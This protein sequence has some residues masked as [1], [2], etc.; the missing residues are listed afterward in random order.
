MDRQ[1]YNRKLIFERNGQMNNKVKRTGNLYVALVVILMVVAVV[2]AIAGAMSRSAQVVDVGVDGNAVTNAAEDAG[3]MDTEDVADVFKPSKDNESDSV[4]DAVTEKTEAE[5][6][7]QFINPTG[8]KLI[9]EYSIE[10]PVF[11][12]TMEDYRTHSGVDIFV[13]NGERILAA[14]GG[15]VKE[16]W[17]DPMMGTCISISHAG[18]A[19]SIYMN[20]SPDFPE[21]IAVGA[22][23]S[24]GTF[25]A[26]GGESALAEISEEPHVHFELKI[27]GEY[28]DPCDYIDFSQGEEIYED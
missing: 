11:S 5:P 14:A 27:N 3:A 28:V 16:I 19:E 22:N 15:T 7:P 17:E 21:G 12:V 9:S 10:V 8:G 6:I 4:T 25:I 26:V 2:A 20:V 18:G 24:E 23:V 1:K 13:S